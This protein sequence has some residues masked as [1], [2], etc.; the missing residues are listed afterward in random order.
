[1]T[2]NKEELKLLIAQDRLDEAIK[3]LF[4]QITTYLSVNKEDAFV[5][6]LSDT[7]VIN[8]G[9]LN[10]MI[11]DRNQGTLNREDERITKAEIERS[12]LYII[13]Q[14]PDKVISHSKLENNKSEIRTGFKPH[15][16]KNYLKYLIGI[17]FL[18]I[19]VSAI[20]YILPDNV[21][22]TKNNHDPIRFNV[23]KDSLKLVF[24]TNTGINDTFI[25]GGNESVE[26][27]KNALIRHYNLFSDIK[28]QDN[29]EKDMN[30][31]YRINLIANHQKL[32]NESASLIQS[33]VRNLDEI[34]IEYEKSQMAVLS[35]LTKDIKVTFKGLKFNNPTFMLKNLNKRGKIESETSKKVTVKFS[36]SPYNHSYIFIINNNGK[37]YEINKESEVDSF[38]VNIIRK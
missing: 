16:R 12:I 18:I 11:E 38:E 32:Q 37:L 27:L 3:L 30:Y 8:S 5:D 1:M 35:P 26:F 13:D 25:I 19:S 7:L 4:H 33:G 15:I 17:L 10:A 24:R 28:K 22:T 21:Q 20:Y 9:Q 31:E 29:L 6:K 14:L 34:N 23:V 2:I 36:V